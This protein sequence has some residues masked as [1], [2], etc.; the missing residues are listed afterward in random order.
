[1]LKIQSFYN[2]LCAYQDI[3]SPLLKLLDQVVVG[4]LTSHGI[5][6]HSCNPC[7]GKNL[8]KMLFNFF[9][10]EIFLNE[11][12][13][14]ADGAGIHNAVDRSAIMANQF[15]G[16]LVKGEA[17]ITVFA[18]RYPAAGRAYLVRKIPSPVLKEYTL[19]VSFQ[20]CLY[21]CFQ[22]G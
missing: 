20:G 15:I 2:H 14:A 11:L 1:M 9:R 3:N 16:E 7:F 6:I 5:N 13:I 4:M 18:L 19:P 22:L 21:G 12:V 17:D 8:F 10:A